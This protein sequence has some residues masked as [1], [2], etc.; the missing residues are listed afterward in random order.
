MSQRTCKQI[1]IRLSNILMAWKIVI[2]NHHV[3][4]AL[5][6]P[7][8]LVQRSQMDVLW[9]SAVSSPRRRTAVKK[10]N[11][12][13]IKKK[14]KTHQQIK[15]IWWQ[16]FYFWHENMLFAVC[17]QNV[18]EHFVVVYVTDWLLISV[19]GHRP[20]PEVNLKRP[21]A[22]SQTRLYGTGFSEMRLY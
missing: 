13:G 8:D 2:F 20:Q 6:P 5:T 14:Q 16:T 19:T 7:M 22:T 3:M 11:C 21:R 18:R 9:L 4:A 17:L 15:L 12:A 10:E 1:N